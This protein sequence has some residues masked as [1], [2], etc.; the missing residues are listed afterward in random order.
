[1][2]SNK[3]KK[4]VLDFYNSYIKKKYISTFLLKV[5]RLV[6]IRPIGAFNI[7]FIY[8]YNQRHRLLRRMHYS[9]GPQTDFV[10]DDGFFDVVHYTCTH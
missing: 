6:F 7:K 4:R 9:G 5:Q 1:M 10:I 3:R 8:I 2:F